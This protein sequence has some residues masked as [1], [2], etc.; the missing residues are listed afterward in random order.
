MNNSPIFTDPYFSRVKLF[1][2]VF[3]L[4]LFLVLFSNEQHKNKETK[5]DILDTKLDKSIRVET[6][7]L[8]ITPLLFYSEKFALNVNKVGQNALYIRQYN[9]KDNCMLGDFYTNTST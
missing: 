9:V 3:L 4:L 7:T 1:P 2:I 6:K 8:K 5:C